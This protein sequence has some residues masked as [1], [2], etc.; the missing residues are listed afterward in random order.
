V[1][2]LAQEDAYSTNAHCKGLFYR[3][4]VTLQLMA[5]QATPPLIVYQSKQQ[6]LN[7]ITP[8]KIT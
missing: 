8:I 4:S 3:P 6:A 7:L 2:G 5:E 1:Q